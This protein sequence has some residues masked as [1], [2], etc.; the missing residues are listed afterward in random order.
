MS[1]FRE[2]I[3][4]RQN[5]LTGRWRVYIGQRTAYYCQTWAEA[6]QHAD[7]LVAKERAKRAAR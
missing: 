5:P 6:M 2:R 3:E 4:V 7:E 1:N